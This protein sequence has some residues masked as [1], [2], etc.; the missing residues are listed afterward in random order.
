MLRV[1]DSTTIFGFYLN[2][3]RNALMGDVN[4]KTENCSLLP[5][6]TF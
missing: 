1:F 5:L 2:D 4:I 3:I 6:S